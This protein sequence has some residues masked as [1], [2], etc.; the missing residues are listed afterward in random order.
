MTDKIPVDATI[1]EAY[2]FAF[3]D[4]LSI[5]GVIWFPAA[6]VAVAGYF[7]GGHLI[8]AFQ[9]SLQQPDMTQLR[10]VLPFFALFY[11]TVLLM[12]VMQ[13]VGVTELALGLRSK[14]TFFYFSLGKTFWRVIAA[15]VL[16]MLILLAINIGLSL[17]V[18]LVAG[19]GAAV[20][21]MAAGGA[22]ETSGLAAG[23]TG[24]IAALVMIVICGAMIYASARLTFLLTPAVIAEKKIAIGRSWSLSRG[25]FWRIVIIWLAVLLPL[26]LAITLVEFVVIFPALGQMLMASAQ[27]NMPPQQSLQAYLRIVSQI[28]AG[29]HTYW[30]ILYPVGL[31]VSVIYLGLA[32]G[33]HA[34]AYRGLVPL[35]TDDAA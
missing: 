6:I 5:L 22:H 2:G 27:H 7:L 8:Y 14:R 15:W 9:H 23:I 11:L 29:A 35:K 24:L 31:V 10:H 13:Y 12:I 4:F 25:N 16:A 20:T 26:M 1:T 28:G 17:A 18:G 30:Y 33:M 3:G 32:A 21:G 19:I 34:F